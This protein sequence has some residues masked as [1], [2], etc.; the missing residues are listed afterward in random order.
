MPTFII[1][2][3]GVMYR[4]EDGAIVSH[5]V[6]QYNPTNYSHQ[7]ST[8]WIFSDA[9][10]QFLPVAVFGKF[11]ER[12]LTF[13]LFLYGREKGEAYGSADVERQKAQLE[14]FCMPGSAFSKSN[15]HSVSSGRVKLIMG[16]SVYNGVIP[17]L[18]F[19]HTMFD[20][21]LETTMATVDVNFK[22]TS[23]GFQ[24]DLAYLDRIRRRAQLG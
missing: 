19:S 9:L 6:F 15:P 24:N 20:K 18:K 8:D 4:I 13:T 7:V 14:L 23:H 12:S 21:K 16:R 17:S 10:G 1:R 2:E 3:K 5:Y 22:I 11:G